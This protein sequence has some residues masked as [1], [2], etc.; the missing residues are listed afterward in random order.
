MRDIRKN[1]QAVESFNSIVDRAFHKGS[2]CR[3]VLIDCCGFNDA[4]I[5]LL[6]RVDNALI[7]DSDNYFDKKDNFD[8]YGMARKSPSIHCSIGMTCV[9]LMSMH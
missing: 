6:K 1:I 8:E 3:D 2:D 7:K 5:S 9:M 4:M